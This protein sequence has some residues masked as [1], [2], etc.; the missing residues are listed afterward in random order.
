MFY[1]SI[2]SGYVVSVVNFS[3]ILLGRSYLIN[4]T[5]SPHN[6]RLLQFTVDHIAELSMTVDLG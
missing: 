4:P 2:S 3:A 6:P 5:I 1:E